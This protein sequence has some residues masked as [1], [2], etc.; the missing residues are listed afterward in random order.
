MSDISDSQIDDIVA[1]LDGFVARGGGHMN[2]DVSDAVSSDEK[3]VEEMG[4][5][6]CSKNAFAC[7]APTL[8]EGM[9][10]LSSY[11]DDYKK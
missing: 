5:V 6:D 3:V 7:S 4:C 11:E 8:L 1:M 9:D 10:D 2:V